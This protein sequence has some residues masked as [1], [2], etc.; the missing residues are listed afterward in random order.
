MIDAAVL[1]L[2]RQADSPKVCN[3]IKVAQGKRGFN[4]LTR[5]TTLCSNATGGAIMAYAM[6]ARIAALPTAPPDGHCQK[7]RRHSPLPAP[8]AR[9]RAQRYCL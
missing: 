7:N 3:A 4:A 2:P 1:T 5:G 6:T 8:S 9:K